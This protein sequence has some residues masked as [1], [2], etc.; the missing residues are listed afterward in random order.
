LSE[1]NT[2]LAQSRGFNQEQFEL[3]LSLVEILLDVADRRG[4]DGA[5]RRARSAFEVASRQFVPAL[6]SQERE[7]YAERLVQLS[8]RLNSA[9]SLSRAQ[10]SADDDEHQVETA[11]DDLPEMLLQ[12]SEDFRESD[13]F[14]QD[15]GK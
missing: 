9:T 15:L 10:S 2:L 1:S 14:R 7:F 8:E 12:S 5:V 13:R 11:S 3:Q 6:S 4:T